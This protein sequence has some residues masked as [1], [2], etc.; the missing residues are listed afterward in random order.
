MKYRESMKQA[1]IS[2]LEY[3]EMTEKKIPVGGRIKHF[4]QSWGK[5]SN[6]Q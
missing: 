4:L 6:N 1:R 3:H 5:L 2:N